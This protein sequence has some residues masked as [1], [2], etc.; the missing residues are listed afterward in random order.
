MALKYTLLGFLNLAPMTG[1]ELKKN[2]DRSTQAFWHAGLNQIYPALKALEE[3]GL[4]SART[5]P[6][7][8][9]PDR[10]VYRITAGGRAELLQWLRRPIHEL[11]P[12]KNVAL[13]K[14]F[15]AGYLHRD[16]ILLHLRGQLELHQEE[17]RRYRE[18]V[19][20]MIAEIVSRT[21]R[22]REGTMWEL[23]R[24][25]GESH[26]RTYADWLGGAIRTVEAME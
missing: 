19:K 1:Y 18:D 23:V 26:E 13:L 17:L 10:R 22:K 11:P 21:G 9:R 16:E 7:E 3:T 14:L 8:G 2:L 25:L 6:Q 4:V 20:P 24:E 5:A 15:F 12:S